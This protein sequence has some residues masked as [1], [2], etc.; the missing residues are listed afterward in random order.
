M[1]MKSIITTGMFFL[2]PGHIEAFAYAEQCVS[3]MARHG[4]YLDIKQK[5]DMVFIFG[6]TAFMT[7]FTRAPATLMHVLYAILLTSIVHYFCTVAKW[8]DIIC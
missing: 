4:V 5:R 8:S 2:P 3:N 7:S 1:H 6:A